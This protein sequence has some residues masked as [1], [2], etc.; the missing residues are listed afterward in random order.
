MGEFYH[1][2]WLHFKCSGD[3]AELFDYNLPPPHYYD[4]DNADIYAIGWLIDG[5]FTTSKGIAYLNDIVARIALSVPVMARIE[6]APKKTG[7]T[8]IKLRYL[9]NAVSLPPDVQTRI[10][11]EGFY[12]DAVFWAIKLQAER[13]IR[14]YDGWFDYQ[15]L[16]TW[17]LNS[18]FPEKERST[19]RAKC[20]S[21]WHWYEQRDF[22]IPRYKHQRGSRMSREDA[23]K[24]A[25]ETL[26]AEKKAKVIGAIESMKFLEKKITVSGVARHAGVSRDTAR[27]YLKWLGLIG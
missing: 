26:A 23:A 14:V 5:C 11:S 1:N 22:T 9:Q 3:G 17:A 16:E 2:T 25:R 20:R 8:P 4:R 15:R 6:E 27:K 24:I 12:H 18:F 7:G 10:A 21:V 13:Y 19:L